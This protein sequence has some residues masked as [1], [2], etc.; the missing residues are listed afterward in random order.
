MSHIQA[1]TI[2]E[3]LDGQ[4]EDAKPSGAAGKNSYTVSTLPLFAVL[5][6]DRPLCY[7]QIL[8]HPPLLSLFDSFL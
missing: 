5:C 6:A 2:A 7:A 1:G 8:Q 3:E 4:L